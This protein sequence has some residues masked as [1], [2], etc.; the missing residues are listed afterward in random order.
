MVVRKKL[1]PQILGPFVVESLAEMK[2][3]T[4]GV[5]RGLLRPRDWSPRDGDEGG[6]RKLIHN[7]FTVDHR[8]P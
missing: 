6:T 5:S 2:A 1:S 7:R 8:A 3:V 4:E